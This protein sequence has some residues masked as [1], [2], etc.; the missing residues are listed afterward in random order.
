M[1]S[2]SGYRYAHA[3]RGLIGGVVTPNTWFTHLCDFFIIVRFENYILYSASYFFSIDFSI[4]YTTKSNHI[5]VLFVPLVSMSL[6]TLSMY[7]A[8]YC[9]KLQLL[10]TG[11]AGALNLLFGDS[12]SHALDLLRLVSLMMDTSCIFIR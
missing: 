8:Q 1:V 12:A 6:Y 11:T 2:Q 7:T 10:L 3:S 5:I 9:L 4:L